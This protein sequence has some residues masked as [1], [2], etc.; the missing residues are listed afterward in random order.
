[1]VLDASVLKPRFLK[2]ETRLIASRNQIGQEV[3]C[4]CPSNEMNVNLAKV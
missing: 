3:F 4:F 1:V 2:V